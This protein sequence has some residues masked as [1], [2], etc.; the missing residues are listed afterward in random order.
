MPVSEVLGDILERPMQQLPHSSSMQPPSA[1][2]TSHAGAGSA[3]GVTP[4][5]VTPFPAAAHRKESKVRRMHAC[6]Q[7]LVARQQ[8]PRAN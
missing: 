5:P 3:D 1:T 8:S 6:L 2:T 4:P 7:G